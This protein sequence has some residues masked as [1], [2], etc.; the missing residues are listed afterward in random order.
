[1]E[2]N[3]EM[4][5]GSFT[6]EASVLV[7]ML[8]IIYVLIIN[9]GLYMYTEIREQQEQ[10]AQSDIWVIDDFYKYQLMKGILYDK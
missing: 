2:G 5:K 1:M 7:P 3:E 4:L 8:L 9:T 10:E 6:V